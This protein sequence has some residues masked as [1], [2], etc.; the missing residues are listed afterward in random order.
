MW[1]P[2][3]VESDNFI[4]IKALVFTNCHSSFNTSNMAFKVRNWMLG[5]IR[6]ARPTA[7]ECSVSTI[8]PRGVFSVGLRKVDC[9]LG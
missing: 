6:I 3:S 5:R 7:A 1:I 2:D 9:I 4:S 8:N